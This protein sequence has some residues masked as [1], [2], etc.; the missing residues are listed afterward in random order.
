MILI[1]NLYT[2]KQDRSQQGLWEIIP[3]KCP[4]WGK[5]KSSTASNQLWSNAIQNSTS[6]LSCLSLGMFLCRCQDSNHHAD[7]SPSTTKLAQNTPTSVR[8]TDD[9][10]THPRAA[11]FCSSKLFLTTWCVFC[12][13]K[14]LSDVSLKSP[15]SKCKN[16]E[17]EEGS[18]ERLPPC[19]SSTLENCTSVFQD[20]LPVRPVS[21]AFLKD[22]LT[23]WWRIP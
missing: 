4:H 12:S 23:I 8:Y 5:T 6:A 15:T 19:F 14:F 7:T 11:V 1:I 16:Q 17:R 3:A 21:Q 10:H 20:M 9:A 22:S 2:D 18:W 13:H